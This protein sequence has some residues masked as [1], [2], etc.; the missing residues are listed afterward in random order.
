MVEFLVLFLCFYVWHALGVTVGYHR[1]LS[2]RSFACPKLIE[3]FFVSGGYLAFEGSPIWWATIHRAH[4]RYSDTPLD[5]HSPLYGLQNAHVGWLTNSSYPSHVCPE[6]HS[7]DLLKDPLYRFLEQD[8]TWRKAHFCVFIIGLLFRAMIWICFGWVAALASLLAGFAVL[9]IPLM[10]NVVCHT[11]RLGYKTYA[12]GD[13]SVNVWWVAIL[14]MG[15]GWHNNHHASPGSAK[16]GMRWWELDVSWLI[17]CVLKKLHLVS[18]VNEASQRQMLRYRARQGSNTAVVLPETKPLETVAWR[19]Q[20]NM[21]AD[22][23][24]GYTPASTTENIR[25]KMQTK[26][27]VR[28]LSFDTDVTLLQELFGAF[29]PVVSAEIS[30]E[31]ATGTGRGFAMVEMATQVAAEAAIRDLNMREL[32]GRQLHVRFADI[33]NRKGKSGA[34]KRRR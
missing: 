8:G 28:N 21:P 9:Q 7:K 20:Q 31:V 26:L 19:V 32:N 17:I 5:P 27:F 16:T 4:H 6:H 10:L 23:G 29:G 24:N 13:H 12:T 11:R 15:E 34:R 14:A 2:H 3:Y 30:K 22:L 25:R 33:N 18:R 1:L